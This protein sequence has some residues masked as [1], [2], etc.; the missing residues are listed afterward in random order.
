MSDPA[1]KKVP[2][3]KNKKYNY[4]KYYTYKFI[5]TNNL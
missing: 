5:I 3:K 1:T 2:D 4:L